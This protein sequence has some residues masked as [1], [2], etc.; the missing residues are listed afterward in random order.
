MKAT[1]Y[2]FGGLSGGAGSSA[3]GIAN[4]NVSR[5][6]KKN[7]NSVKANN[8]NKLPKKKL[9]Y[10]P[11]EIRNALMLAS[12]SQSAGRV[13]VQ[14]KGK[15]SSL[16]KWKGSG[17]FNETELSNAIVH[18]RRMVQ[19]AQMKS[20]NLKKEEE[21]QKRYAKREE[22]E[23]QQQKIERKHKIQQKKRVIEQKEKMEKIQKAHKQKMHEQ[24]VIRRRRMN[25]LKE[26]GK[27]DEADREYKNNMGRDCG[28]N[29]SAANYNMVYLPIEGVE[30]EL[31]D[32]ALGLNEE[33]IEQQVEMMIQAELG[34]TS[35]SPDLSLASAG[36]M[37]MS[38]S[39]GMEVVAVVDVTV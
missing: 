14:A 23:E 35:V 19:C 10:N 13:L 18:A 26:Q 24:E 28:E 12:K 9:N 36:D 1:S 33:Q 8:K 4:I 2:Q 30:M 5:N 11:R 29:S 31:S 22:R 34:M 25:R 32:A 15:L 17:Q 6:N 39:A 27:M 20:R 38:D 21:L 7:T 16:M 37:A 3:K